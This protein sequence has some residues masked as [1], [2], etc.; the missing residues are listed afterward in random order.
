[1]QRFR[2]LE[3]PA[4]VGFEAFGRTRQE[5]FANAAR[6]LTDLRVD[7]ATVA[8]SEMFEITVRSLDWAGLLVNWL[9]EILYLEDAENWLFCDFEFG[10]FGLSSLIAQARGEKFDPARH[11][12]K[13]L[14]KAITYHQLAIENQGDFWRAQIFVDV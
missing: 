5:M 2:F 4:D 11:H 10:E 3:H 6:A 8:P 1:M 9:S 14:V 12:L 13:G 7:L